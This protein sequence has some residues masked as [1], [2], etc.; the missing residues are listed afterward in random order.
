MPMIHNTVEQLHQALAQAN[1]W[2][3]GATAVD[4]AALRSGAID[5][6]I[7]TA[8]F[9]TDDDTRNEARTLIHRFARVA[10]AVP[11]S[12]LPLYEAIG[13]G[14]VTITVPAHNIL[15]LSYDLARALFRAALKHD[16]GAF[17]F[18]IARSEIGYTEQRPGEYSACVLAAAIKEGF[19]GPV[20]LQG[21]HF[22]ASAKRWT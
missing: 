20:F 3:G 21:D 7:R 10:G 1:V 4:L 12:I 19:R 18:E 16:V 14:E 6:L 9:S 5:E 2:H 8:V 11:A 22:Q 13:R 15:A 17:I